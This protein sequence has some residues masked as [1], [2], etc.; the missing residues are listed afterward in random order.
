VGQYYQFSLWLT[1]SIV[2]SIES[3]STSSRCDW[4]CL[5]SSALHHVVPV[6]VAT[7]TCLLYSA[8]RHVVPALVATD[9][10][11]LFSALHHVVP[12]LVTGT[13]LLSSALGHVVP[14]LVVTDTYL[15]SSALRHTGTTQLN[16]D[17]YYH[18]YSGTHR[19]DEGG[20]F[21]SWVCG[22][23]RGVVP[24]TSIH[25]ERLCNFRVWTQHVREANRFHN[26]WSFFIAIT[27]WRVD[28]S[29]PYFAEV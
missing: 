10:Y 6:L 12:A 14:V 8:L 22:G 15:L 11:L 27:N 21:M 17:V 28:H 4:H 2:L 24:Q 13:Y 9:T 29:P 20:W 25:F 23:R 3:C 1:L 26:S 5:L 19:E 18:V 16:Q 7:D